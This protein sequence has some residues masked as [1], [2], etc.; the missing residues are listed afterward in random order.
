MYW[1]TLHIILK[2]QAQKTSMVTKHHKCHYQVL[3]CDYD[4]NVQ[5][6]IGWIVMTFGTDIHAPKR[7]GL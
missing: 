1:I 4:R 3:I 6:S 7:G 5:T 2:G